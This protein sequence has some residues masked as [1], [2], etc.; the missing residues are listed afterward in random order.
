MEKKTKGID[1]KDFNNN[2]LIKYGIADKTEIDN[3]QNNQQ[4]NQTA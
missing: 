4:V 1:N 2:E 3:L